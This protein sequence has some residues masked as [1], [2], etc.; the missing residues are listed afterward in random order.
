MGFMG[1]E[2]HAEHFFD[3]HRTPRSR[4]EQSASSSARLVEKKSSADNAIMVVSTSSVND[5]TQEQTNQKS[6]GNDCKGYVIDTSYINNP[7][8]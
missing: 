8:S 2:I 5:S 7:C 1:G 6:A 3:V 4:E